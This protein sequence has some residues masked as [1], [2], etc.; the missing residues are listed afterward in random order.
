MTRKN[1]RL[2]L[3]MKKM[4]MEMTFP[5]S[6]LPS[7]NNFTIQLNNFDSFLHK[8]DTIQ[9]ATKFKNAKLIILKKK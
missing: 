6:D 2:S 9:N 8:K 1:L 5:C 7:Y 4:T 3:K